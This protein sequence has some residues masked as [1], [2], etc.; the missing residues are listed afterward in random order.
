M[1]I[2]IATLEENNCVNLFADRRIVKENK[3]MT[4]IEKGEV[5]KIFELTDST[6]CGMTG[7]GEW[8]ISLA[9][10]LIKYQDKSYPFYQVHIDLDRLSG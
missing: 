10:E 4:Y 9:N 3:E 6:S 7:D 1:S 5:T 8:G 2:V